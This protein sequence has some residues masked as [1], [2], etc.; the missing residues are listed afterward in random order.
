M[1][2]RLVVFHDDR[3]E[4]FMGDYQD[5]L[6]KGGWEEDEKPPA[7]SDSSYKDEKRERAEK[8]VMRSKA[9]KPITQQIEKLEKQII[10]LESEVDRMNQELVQKVSQGEFAPEL[11]KSVKEKQN[12]IDAL[13]TALET[14]YEELE[15]AKKLF[16]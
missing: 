10:T 8:I 5:F 7:K 15:K 3:Q 12:S 2:N 14:S 11:A 6:E 4:L 13:F 16:S 9:L 1:C